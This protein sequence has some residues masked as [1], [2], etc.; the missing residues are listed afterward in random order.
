MKSSR[1]ISQ[2]PHKQHD[3]YIAKL[4]R[5]AEAAK[6]AFKDLRTWIDSELQ[7]TEYYATADAKMTEWEDTLREL[8]E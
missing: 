5:V 2:Y 1:R 7:G 6:P 8:E 3:E 4:E